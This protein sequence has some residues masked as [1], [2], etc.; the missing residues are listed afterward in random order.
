MK[1]SLTVI[2]VET[3]EELVDRYK[4]GSKFVAAFVEELNAYAVAVAYESKH[5]S[6]QGESATQPGKSLNNTLSRI[7][8]EN[9]YALAVAYKSSHTGYSGESAAKKGGSLKSIISRGNGSNRI[10]YHIYLVHK[11]Q[12]EM[13]WLGGD[14]LDS[15]GYCYTLNLT[16]QTVNK[17][18]LTDK[19]LVVAEDYV[20][21]RVMACAI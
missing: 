2:K 10:D 8:N 15:F 1:E 11:K 20:K 18:C 21:T 17:K 12:I 4:Y 7:D 9:R 19:E 6:N 16:D 5:S 13:Y 14:I 3:M